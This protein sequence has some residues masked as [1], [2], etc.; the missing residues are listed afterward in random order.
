MRAAWAEAG[1]LGAAGRPAA[2]PALRRAL[3][4]VCLRRKEAG[5]WGKLREKLGALVHGGSRQKEGP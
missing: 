1:L 5:V 4:E 3:R 2:A